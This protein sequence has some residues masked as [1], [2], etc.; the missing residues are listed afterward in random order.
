MKA[1]VYHPGLGCRT[2]DPCSFKEVRIPD[3]N[4]L[5]RCE[6]LR[7]CVELVAS[8]GKQALVKPQGQVERIN[9]SFANRKSHPIVD[10]HPIGYPQ[11]AAFTKSDKNFLI[12]R[13]YGFLRARVLLYRQDEL[14]VLEMDL[15][16]MDRDDNIYRP[17]ALYSRRYVSKNVDD[18][19]YSREVLMRKID[20]KLKEYGKNLYLNLLTTEARSYN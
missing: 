8:F 7:V 16:A 19:L 6:D 13:K 18:P 14:S 4:N 3:A 12:A 15:I 9:H 11:L 20:D 5:C 10:D 2:E 1:H 17:L